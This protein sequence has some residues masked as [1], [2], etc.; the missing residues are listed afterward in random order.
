MP[1]VQIV[2]T[3]LCRG[4][5]TPVLLLLLASGACTD[6]SATLG[7]RSDP[8]FARQVTGGVSI[9][10]LP[11]LGGHA[12]VYSINDA[13]IAVGYS[14]LASGPGY[15]YAARWAQTN[16]V[17]TV[18]QVGGLGTTASAINEAGTI[19]GDS[20]LVTVVWRDGGSVVLGRGHAN[21]INEANTVVGIRYEPGLQAPAAWRQGSGGWTVTS[22]DRVP[23]T[24][25]NIYCIG[26]A[27]AISGSG[28]VVGF[29]FDSGCVQQYAVK[30]MPKPDP[31]DGW[32]AAEPLENAAGMAKSIPYAIVGNTIVGVAW[33]CAVLDGCP[34][35]AYRWSLLPGSSD[36]GPL[37]SLDARAN[38]LNAL[39]ESV[40]SYLSPKRMR[41]V[42]W[43]SAGAPTTLPEVSTF[44][45]HWVWD[46]NN[47]A[48]G[49]TARLAVGGA[50][51]DRGGI[52]PPLVWTIP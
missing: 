13:N 3:I 34:R 18:A 39:G 30:W 19:V 8:A 12:Q 4:L 49:R 9:A 38:G 50:T 7:P 46:I 26:E 10:Q 16:G 31:A 43:S 20:G 17:W 32:E 36:T 23:G 6:E 37:G 44:N 42:S 52:S 51:S 21:G 35:R 48:A 40:G 5:A 33:P 2:T 28:I 22:L 47:P 14:T 1:R 24:T 25:G 27:T 45:T 15:T 41:A 11:T 29:L